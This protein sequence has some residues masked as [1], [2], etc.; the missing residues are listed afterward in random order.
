MICL[1]RHLR[2]YLYANDYIPLSYAA[3]VFLFIHTCVSIC[4]SVCAYKA[5]SRMTQYNI[6]IGQ[7]W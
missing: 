5:V 6:V 1:H 3:Y 4:V 7:R 2:A